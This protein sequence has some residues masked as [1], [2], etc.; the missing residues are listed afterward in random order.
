MWHAFAPGFLPLISGD[1]VSYAFAVPGQLGARVEATPLRVGN[2]ALVV[3]GSVTRSYPSLNHAWNPSLS[4]GWDGGFNRRT[5]TA[6]S[7]GLT[8]SDIPSV[9]GRAD[10][11]SGGPDKRYTLTAGVEYARLAKG[12][13]NSADQESVNVHALARI[14][15]LSILPVTAAA[16]TVSVRNYRGVQGVNAT[17][18]TAAAMAE[19]KGDLGNDVWG[20]AHCAISHSENGA[21]GMR[22]EALQAGGRVSSHAFTLS[23]AFEVSHGRAPAGYAQNGAATGIQL[24]LTYR[25]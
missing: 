13:L 21:D 1:E 4:A 17:A 20:A 16:E 7:G 12:A 8:D 14:D 11:V 19:L 18:F 2:H 22:I 25:P 3:G 9:F 5:A 15:L 10:V 24:G 6:Q 23:A